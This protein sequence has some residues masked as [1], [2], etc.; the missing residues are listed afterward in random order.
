M[1]TV[2]LNDGTRFETHPGAVVTH[3][4]FPSLAVHSVESPGRLEPPR[5]FSSASPEG[6]HASPDE[7]R[8]KGRGLIRCVRVC[9]C[10]RVCGCVLFVC[11]FCVLNQNNTNK[12]KNSNT[13]SLKVKQSHI[14]EI[15]VSNFRLESVIVKCPWVS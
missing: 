10:E 15:A 6:N 2:Q 5:N 12:S 3:H 13:V 9:G 14:V 8:R 4:H 1:A 7:R 11:S